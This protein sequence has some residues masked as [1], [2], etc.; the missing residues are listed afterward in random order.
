M[1]TD[2]A[3]EETPDD[4]HTFRFTWCSR[5]SYQVAG[6]EHYTDAPAFGEDLAVTVDVR[7]W[8]LRAAI[9]KLGRLPFPVLMGADQEDCCDQC[10]DCP[11]SGEREC[12]V[13]GGFDICC[14]NLACPGRRNER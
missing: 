4:G 8:S 10:Y 1:T 7:A 13:H 2:P 14:D 12:R 11:T 9:E 6:D 5:G 3:K